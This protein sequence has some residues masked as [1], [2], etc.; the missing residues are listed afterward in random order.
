MTGVANRRHFDEFLVEQYRIAVRYHQPFSLAIIDL[1]NFKVV[2]DSFG[3]GPGDRVLLAVATA[4]RDQAR[5]A[6]LVAR[7]GGDEFA[8]VMPGTDARGAREAAERLRQAVARSC[9]HLDAS[10]GIPVTASLGIAELD[11]SRHGSALGLLADADR[12]VYAAKSSGRNRV[13][14]AFSTAA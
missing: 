6:D 9:A 8:V 14:D 4:L 10:P 13:S 11:V 7:I 3:H 1:D 2:N 5:S 12:G